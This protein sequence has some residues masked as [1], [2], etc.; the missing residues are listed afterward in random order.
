MA[1]SDPATG[2]YAGRGLVAAGREHSLAVTQDGQLWTWGRNSEGQ[3][4]MGDLSDQALPT[5]VP[6]MTPLVS[7][8][9]SE[10]HSLCVKNGQVFAWGRNDYGQLGVA[11][12]L[13]TTTP[14]LSPAP[15]PTFTA[16]PIIK[17]AA[18]ANHSLALAQDGTVWAWGRNLNGQLAQPTST[19][20]NVVPTQITSITGVIDLAAGDNHSLA[21]LGSGGIKSWGAG[22]SGQLGNSGSG[23]SSTPVN[24]SSISTAVTVSARGNISM[25][26]LANGHVWTWG[27]GNFSALGRT[28]GSYYTPSRISYTTQAATG[29]AAGMLHS[30]AILCD[31]TV[32]PWGSGTNGRLGLGDKVAATPMLSVPSLP[33]VLAISVGDHTMAAQ[34]GGQ[35]WAWGPNAK[36]QLGDGFTGS[37]QSRSFPGRVFLDQ[38]D[39][40][41]DGLSDS[42]ELVRGTSPTNPD[43]NADGLSDS[44]N[45]RRGR[46]PVSMD[47]DGDGWTNALEIAGGTNPF[48]ADSDR[49]GV[50]DNIDPF[51]L[52]PMRSATVPDNGL[53]PQMTIQLPAGASLIP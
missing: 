6:G 37:T 2:V 30:A 17:V 51:P 36:G 5:L 35:F 34:N 33:N 40:D 29:I 31:G 39:T 4:G 44:D 48:A 8:S 7:I 53:H 21:V 27:A 20:T 15:V 50:N 26:L 47:V 42:E 25:A 23:S 18:G 11:T 1:E 28:T 14:L 46:D 49:D 52:D 13:G 38:A 43:T 9:A 16:S 32:L 45:I 10:T 41:G 12:N 19:T 3:L 22:L 24:V